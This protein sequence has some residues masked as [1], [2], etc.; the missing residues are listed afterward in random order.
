MKFGSGLITSPEL[1][2]LD[3]SDKWL[4][5][6]LLKKWTWSTF[7]D[8]VAGLWTNKVGFTL[9]TS[10]QQMQ[11]VVTTSIYSLLW[12][13]ICICHFFHYLGEF[14]LQRVIWHYLAT[15]TSMGIFLFKVAVA[16]Y[17][18]MAS[19]ALEFEVSPCK[20]SLNCVS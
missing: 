12:F 20:C 14:L 5:S 8:F 15:A 10:T 3:N 7:N 9:A 17:L 6:Y 16:S 1:S 18:V 11:S 13:Y 19:T 4:Q 2:Y